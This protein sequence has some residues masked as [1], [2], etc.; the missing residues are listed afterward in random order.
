LALQKPFF[1]SAEQFVYDSVLRH[2]FAMA[3]ILPSSML[4]G[5]PDSE[6]LIQCW[7]GSGPYMGE[8]GL[9]QLADFTRGGKDRIVLILDIQPFFGRISDLLGEVQRRS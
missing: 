6:G 4:A 2:E 8:Q 5:S 3:R 9:F 1:T 7:A